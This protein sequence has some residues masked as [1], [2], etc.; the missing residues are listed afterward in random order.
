M[1]SKARY[2]AQIEDM[3]RRASIM[4]KLC[5]ES[6]YDSNNVWI[7]S[8]EG[9][10][11]N[12]NPCEIDPMFESVSDAQAH[13]IVSACQSATK[14]YYDMYGVEPRPEML[15]SAHKAMES[16]LTL[17]GRAKDGSQTGMML[18]SIGESLST[19]DG[20]E[21]RAKFIALILPT[22]LGTATSD[23]VTYIPATHDIQELFK[24]YRVAGSN[25]GDF[26]KGQVIDARTVGQYS[27]MRQ[28]YAFVDAQ[29]PNGTL[30][31]HVFTSATD[32]VNTKFDIPFK[33]SSI[34][35]YVN[36]K[37]VAR[38]MDAQNGHLFGTHDGVTFTGDI[39]YAKGVVTVNTSKA[40]A[41]S[42]KMDVQFEVD[43][44]TAPELI[45]VIDHEMD[46]RKIRP[47]ESAISN[48]QTIQALHA[49]QRE[50]NTNLKSLALTNMRNLLAAEKANNQLAD[51]DYA[52]TRETTFNIF[53]PEGFDWQLQREKLKEKLLNIS[54][55][56]LR[57]C[58]VSGLVGLFCGVGASTII[59]TLGRDNFIPAPN[60][61]QTDKMHFVGTLF[62]M[63]KVFECPTIIAHDDAL[64]Y[65]RGENFA[66]AGYVSGVCVAPTL[67]NHPI[68]ANLRQRETLWELSYDEVHPY[69]GE[70]FFMRLHFVN[71]APVVNLPPMET[72]D[73]PPAAEVGK[74]DSAEVEQKAAAKK[75]STK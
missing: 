70:N 15:A 60:Y 12:V 71:E 20:V 57:T 32:L 13:E 44:E 17:N 35:I 63:F 21:L 75:A 28:R 40:L 18:E 31:E 45:P 22:L 46:S 24:L 23:A 69:N 36:R 55:E 72:C 34:V 25:F 58:K 6:Q 42:D 66:E 1:N 52:C 43:I 61:R 7:D 62:G 73:C 4:D 50:Y 37:P 47:S 53:C 19:S 51:M 16:M 27:K 54:E 9:R 56:L 2:N 30:K 3:M 5:I 59:K 8:A 67:Y 11:N 41:A 48:E 65:A 10:M 38:D 74:G 49:M 26:K 39:D 14:E 68:G 29:Q 64:C 33:K